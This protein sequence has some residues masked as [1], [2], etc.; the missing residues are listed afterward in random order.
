MNATD[1]YQR[2]SRLAG[3]FATFWLQPGRLPFKG[4]ESSDTIEGVSLVSRRECLVTYRSCQSKHLMLRMWDPLA[5]NS[6]TCAF[7]LVMI[8]L[9]TCGLFNGDRQRNDDGRL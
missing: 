9:S 1:R 6:D 3:H 8:S 7:H 2:E 5:V 4:H